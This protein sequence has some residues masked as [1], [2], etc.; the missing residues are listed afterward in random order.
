MTGLTW[1]K[2]VRDQRQ[3]GGGVKLDEA[4]NQPAVEKHQEGCQSDQ[5]KKCNVSG[6]HVNT[7]R[8]GQVARCLC[9]PN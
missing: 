2:G 6:E 8:L 5:R 4:V 7:D 1:A 3:C 9:G